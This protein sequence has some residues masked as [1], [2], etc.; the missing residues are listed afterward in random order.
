MLSIKP[1]VPFVLLWRLL[2]TFFAHLI[3][4]SPLVE[5]VSQTVLAASFRHVLI[6]FTL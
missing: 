4:S 5:R 3:S 2:P 6:L 1:I